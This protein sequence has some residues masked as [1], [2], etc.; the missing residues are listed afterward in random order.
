M[1]RY[2]I[3]QEHRTDEY[4]A[5]MIVMDTEDGRDLAEYQLV[6]GCEKPM[7]DAMRRALDRHLAQPGATL[8]NYQW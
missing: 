7:K 8:G 2:S 1:K 6:S 3:R 5:T 4:Y